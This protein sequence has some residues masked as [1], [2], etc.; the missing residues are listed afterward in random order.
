VWVQ[1]TRFFC[2]DTGCSP[3]LL[4]VCTTASMCLQSCT[5]ITGKEGMAIK[6]YQWFSECPYEALHTP[7]G[8]EL[9]QCPSGT[10]RLTGD[11]VAGGT[12]EGT[13]RCCTVIC[14]ACVLLRYSHA[15]WLD[16]GAVAGCTAAA[17]LGPVTI[18]QNYVSISHKS[19]MDDWVPT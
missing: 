8:N 15:Y 1:C 13:C 5:L 9:P 6:T 16:T 3:H 17:P 2:T 11:G 12:W 18:N 7:N 10:Y 4:L 14:Y 19:D